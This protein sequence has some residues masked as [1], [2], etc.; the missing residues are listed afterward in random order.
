MAA[1]S[2]GRM[3]EHEFQAIAWAPHVDYAGV[4][5]G[6]ADREA[7]IAWLRQ[8]DQIASTLR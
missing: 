4:D 2:L 8:R 6:E 5:R 1:P 3:S 7:E